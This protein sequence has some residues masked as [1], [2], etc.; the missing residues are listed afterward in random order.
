MLA[1][2][3]AHGEDEPWLR[4]LFASGQPALLAMSGLPNGLCQ[5]LV[6]MQYGARLAQYQSRWPRS[7]QQLILLP[8]AFGNAAA[9]DDDDDPAQAAPP[10]AVGMLWTD[11]SA[12]AIQLL[13]IAVLPVWRGQGIGSRCLRVLL[14]QAAREQ[15]PLRLQVALDNPARRLYQRLGFVPD[16]TVDAG[17]SVHLSLIYRPR[18]NHPTETCHEQA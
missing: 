3:T 12:S 14:D 4:A 9:A 6:Q 10:Q 1:F 2:R 5:R 15:R 18:T 11:C 16:N 13:D 8:P 17:H 7:V